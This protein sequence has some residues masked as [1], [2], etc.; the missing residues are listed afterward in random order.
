MC[1]L[2]PTN[3][4]WDVNTQYIH[5]AIYLPVLVE[6]TLALL[7]QVLSKDSL[8]ATETLGCVNVTNDSNHYHRRS[9]NNRDSLD[10]LLLIGLCKKNTKGID[11]LSQLLLMSHG[12][13][14]LF[15][16]S[17]PPNEST[18]L[19]MHTRVMLLL[20][21]DRFT[22]EELKSTFVLCRVFSSLAIVF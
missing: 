18:S 6:P 22:Y 1:K 14:F 7:A 8:E 13:Y 15:G 17:I 20:G 16:G 12:G 3:K 4:H 2:L 5:T 9:L 10:Y 19:T 11:I 21:I